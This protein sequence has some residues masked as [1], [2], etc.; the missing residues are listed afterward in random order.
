[1]TKSFTATTSSCS[2]SKARAA[3]ALALCAFFSAACA[4]RGESFAGYAAIPEERGRLYIYVPPATVTALA[5][6]VYLLLDGRPLTTLRSEG[7]VTVT[8]SPGEHLLVADPSLNVTGHS[9]KVVR[10][11][12][13]FPGEPTLCGYFPTAS[14]RRGRLRCSGEAANHAEIEECRLA[15]LEADA[16][17]QP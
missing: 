14:N 9:T 11:V 1:V 4:Q 16:G 12:H 2:S 10:T 3:A 15:A 17:W 8:L 7:Y 13:V 6:S 5:P